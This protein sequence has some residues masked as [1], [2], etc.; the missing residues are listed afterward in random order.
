MIRL[1]VYKFQFENYKICFDSFNL[2][3]WSSFDGK[4]NKLMFLNK[5]YVFKICKMNIVGICKLNIYYVKRFNYC[6]KFR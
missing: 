6:K 5:V 3:Y 4:N 1:K 2:D